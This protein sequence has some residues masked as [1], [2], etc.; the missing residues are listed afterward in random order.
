MLIE[1]AQN[2]LDRLLDSEDDRVRRKAI[3]DLVRLERKDQVEI[4]EKLVAR[5]PSEGDAWKRAWSYS[6]LGRVNH[7]PTYTVVAGRIDPA[8]EPFHWARYWALASLPDMTRDPNDT[9][10]PTVDDRIQYAA[11][12]ANPMVRALAWRLQLERRLHEDQA[13]QEVLTMLNNDQDWRERVAAC[14]ALRRRE[15]P[16]C[17]ALRDGIEARVLAPL[18]EVLADRHAYADCQWQAAMALGDLANRKEDAVQV[19]AR[20]LEQTST[21]YVRRAIVESLGRLRLPSAQPA[22]LAALLDAEDAQN[23]LQAARAITD[24]AGVPG[25]VQVVVEKLLTEDKPREAYLEALRHIDGPQAAKALEE[26]LHHPDLVRSQRA[27]QALA[28]LGGE[29][30]LRT[31]FAQRARTMEAYSALLGTAD[32]EIMEQFKGMTLE[33]KLAFRGSMIMHYCVFGVGLLLLIASAR[34]AVDGG[35]ATMSRFLGAGGAV[36]SVGLL[37]LTFYKNP[38]ENIRQSVSSLVKTNVVFLGYLRQ[39]NQV[40]ATFKHLFLGSSTFSIDQMQCTVKELQASVKQTL[41]EI[42]EHL[43]S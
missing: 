17:Q 8:M 19:L 24:V 22:L 10:A 18:G 38:L 9:T 3:T 23:R 15:N 25:A 31:L 20:G 6:A 35:E 5:I 34:L 2:V 21:S 32:K 36:G 30:A 12:D 37:L 1:T 29:E 40:D 11:K 43:Q 27:G 4:A 14:K 33:A 7:P 28:R 42:K 16:S 26:A 39:I 41:A 13:L